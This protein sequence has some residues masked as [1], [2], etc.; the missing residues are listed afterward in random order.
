MLL[1]ALAK[2]KEKAQGIGCINNLKQLQLAWVLYSGDYNEQIVRN[3]GLG[4][5]GGA[6][7]SS[8]VI[9]DVSQLPGRTDL[10]T[11]TNANA[12]LYPYSKTVGIYK[13]PADHFKKVNNEA[14]RSISMNWCMNPISAYQNAPGATFFRKQ[15]D[16]TIPSPAMCWVF[17]DENPVT[18]N[19]G[20]FVCDRFN[21]PT[22][23]VDTPASY[24]NKAGGLSFADSHAEIKKWRD[25]AVTLQPSG[26]STPA[27]QNPPVDLNWLQL[28]TT[29]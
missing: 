26:N 15:S 7:Y 12:L 28:R 9:G 23:W 19:D 13:C 14:V 2:A 25:P 18:I 10:G 22:T 11:I 8:W 5:I 29:K 1:P 20:Y 27:V 17:I 4:D 21:A 16:I 6:G 24:H 3:G